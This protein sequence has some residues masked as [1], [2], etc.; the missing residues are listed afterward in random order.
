MKKQGIIQESLC[1][2]RN[3]CPFWL[4]SVSARFYPYEEIETN[5]VFNVDEDSLLTTDEV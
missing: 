5:A 3:V 2:V 1:I 4:Q